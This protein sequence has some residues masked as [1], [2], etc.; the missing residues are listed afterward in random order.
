MRATCVVGGAGGG[1]PPAR[2]LS[3]AR[4]T[5]CH[6]TAVPIQRALTSNMP[7]GDWPQYLN[8]VTISQFVR[9][10]A[11]APRPAPLG[12]TPDWAVGC[13][14]SSR[15]GLWCCCS[16][17]ARSRP[18]ELACPSRDLEDAC[19]P[20]GAVVPEGGE[21]RS[22]LFLRAEQRKKRKKEQRKKESKGGGETGEGEGGGSACQVSPRKA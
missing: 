1:A 13:T 10:I 8:Q 18:H 22:D 7:S 9:P 19:G 21:G 5:V 2:G 17:R 12:R 11:Q 6:W 16:V 20:G 3:L 4:P 15:D 14:S